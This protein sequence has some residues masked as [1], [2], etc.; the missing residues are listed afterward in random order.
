MKRSAPAL[1]TLVDVAKGADVSIGTASRVLNG[2]NSPILI[3]AATRE[4]VRAVAVTLGYR[5]NLAA[6]AMKTRRTNVIGVLVQNS[7]ANPLFHPLLY[8]T[9][10][11]VNHGLDAAGMLTSLVRL[12][13]VADAEAGEPRLFRE[14]AFDGMICVGDIPDRFHAPLRSLCP[15]MT[16]VDGSVFEPTRCLRR[17]EEAA[18]RRAVE[19]LAALG[20]RRVVYLDKPVA[21]SGDHYAFG[22]RRTGVE[23]AARV[24][25]MEVLHRTMVPTHQGESPEAAAQLVPGS[26]LIVADHD[27]MRTVLRLCALRRLA[28]GSDLALVGLDDGQ[29]L[30]QF[31][32]GLSRMRFDRYAM[33]RAA[34]AMLIATVRGGDPASARLADVFEA[35]ETTFRST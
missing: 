22:E 24:A 26:A 29:D 9:I 1:P 8:E 31:W 35:G 16:W 13:D 6:R 11:G 25:G 34:A 30:V 21:T 2:S 7:P 14:H 5:P 33:G 27:L 12:D 17:D 15:V 4:R 28:P 23:T 18:G 19:H 3:S 20:W 32:P 10:L